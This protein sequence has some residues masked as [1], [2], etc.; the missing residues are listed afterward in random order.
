MKNLF[1]CLCR[2]VH[3]PRYGFLYSASPEKC[4][5]ASE[6][7]IGDSFTHLSS[8]ATPE[9][10]T[11]QSF[12]EAYRDLRS[13]LRWPGFI[14]SSLFVLFCAWVLYRALLLPEVFWFFL[15]LLLV[16]TVGQVGLVFE[17]CRLAWRAWFSRHTGR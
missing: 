1:H 5:K 4:K 11:G 7:A 3:G 12:I 17:L 6:F 9:P 8:L 13:P 2:F 15:L 14:A 10:R 16:I